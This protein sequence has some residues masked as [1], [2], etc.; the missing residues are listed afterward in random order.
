MPIYVA[1]HACT[2]EQVHIVLPGQQTDVVHL[3]NPRREELDRSRQQVFV[4][5]PAECVVERAI[6]L[7]QIEIARRRSRSFAAL[8]L[9]A[10]V[11][12]LHQCVDSVRFQQTRTVRRVAGIRSDV[13]HA[14]AVMCI[15]DGDRVARTDRQPG[16]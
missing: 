6:H 1:P 13:D 15:Q 10:H 2:R 12:R 4:I 11:N 5:A 3:R 14:N 16:P 8:S 9:A 7:I